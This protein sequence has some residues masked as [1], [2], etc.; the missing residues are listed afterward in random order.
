MI[1]KLLLNI[2]MIYMIFTKIFKYTSQIKS[3]KTLIVFDDMIAD[4]LSNNKLFQQ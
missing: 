4:V 3:L 2:Q 1:L